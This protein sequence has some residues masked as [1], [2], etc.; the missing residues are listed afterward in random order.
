MIAETRWQP[1]GDV[2]GIAAASGFQFLA[3]SSHLHQDAAGVLEQLATGLGKH[4]AAAVTVKQVLTKLHFQVRDLTAQG[5][6]A[7]RQESG[8]MSETAEFSHM[9]KIFELFE[10]HADSRSYLI[11]TY[12]GIF[13]PI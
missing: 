1:Q 2:P 7:N 13:M 6:L 3:R 5:R 4:H 10:I 12:Q 9:A 11:F 8:G